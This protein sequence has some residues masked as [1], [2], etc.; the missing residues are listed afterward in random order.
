MYRQGDILLVPVTSVPKGYKH[1]PA[2]RAVVA[3]GE[4]TGHHH[5]LHDIEW[6]IAEDRTDQDLEAFAQGTSTFPVFVL[7]P[8]AT[9]LM[10]VDQMDR[11]TQD[12]ETIFVESGLFRVV[13]QRE[14]TPAAPRAVYD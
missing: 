14:Y 2:K 6:V 7:A 10:H 1:V 4:A 5:V 9:E 11:P 12:H 13:R 8:V 3:Y